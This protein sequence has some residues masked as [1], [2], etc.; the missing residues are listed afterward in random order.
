MSEKRDIISQSGSMVFDPVSPDTARL[1]AVE[2]VV[3]AALPHAAGKLKAKYNVICYDN[4]YVDDNRNGV[5]LY[6]IG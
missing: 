6:E 1:E 5:V 2:S 3:I 4:H